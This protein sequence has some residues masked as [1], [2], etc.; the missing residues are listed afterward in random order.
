MLW[1]FLLGG[2][3]FVMLGIAIVRDPARTEALIS[4]GQRRTFG[5]SFG[6]ADERGIAVRRVSL[7]I[8]G[9]GFVLM[10]TFHAVIAVLGLSGVIRLDGV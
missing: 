5:R 7:R 10:G 8:V 2:L 1:L 3:V 6:R 4:S 9:V